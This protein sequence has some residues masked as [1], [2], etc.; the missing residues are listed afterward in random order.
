[1][2]DYTDLMR[3]ITFKYGTQERFAEALGMGRTTLNLKLN[4]KVNF[5]QREIS[6]A[7]GLLS[8]R[9]A[10]IPRY[11]FALKVQKHEQ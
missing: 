3:L 8:I 6:K 5:T 2:Y 7:V 9:K 10:D 1:M 11:F 4:N